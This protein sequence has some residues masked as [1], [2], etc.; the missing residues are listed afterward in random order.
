MLKLSYMSW[1]DYTYVLKLYFIAYSGLY[2]AISN[3]TR[4]KLLMNLLCCVSTYSVKHLIRFTA[5]C[6]KKV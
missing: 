4:I 1:L 2:N 5:D 3:R 6:Y